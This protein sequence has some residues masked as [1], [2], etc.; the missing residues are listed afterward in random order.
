MLR[1]RLFGVA[2]YKRWLNPKFVCKQHQLNG[3]SGAYV[4]CFVN[5]F[6][7]CLVIQLFSTHMDNLKYLQ[8]KNN[9]FN[10]GKNY[11]T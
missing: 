4:H 10:R 2:C 11:D 8:T 6:H 3:L 5:F 9:V 7:M 1:W